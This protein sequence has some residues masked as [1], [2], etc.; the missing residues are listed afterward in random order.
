MELD[1]LILSNITQLHD[2]DLATENEIKEMKEQYQNDYSEMNNQIAEFEEITDIYEDWYTPRKTCADISSSQSGLYYIR[3]DVNA[4][5]FQVFC[6]FDTSPPTTEI[7]H[8]S[9][10]EMPVNGCESPFCYSRNVVYQAS[11]QQI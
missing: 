11:M 2:D 9:E 7:G 4:E 8:D 3:P 1:A 5:S 6:N 10:Y